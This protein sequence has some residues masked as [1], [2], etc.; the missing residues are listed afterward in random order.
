MGSGSRQVFDAFD[1]VVFSG[2]EH[3][4]SSITARPDANEVK[5]QERTATMGY[6]ISTS[7]S[8]NTEHMLQ[9]NNINEQQNESRRY[10][11]WRVSNENQNRG[12]SV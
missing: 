7:K 10:V 1:S 11:L 8:I 9:D 4:F 5:R 3:Q 6:S 2:M 12:R